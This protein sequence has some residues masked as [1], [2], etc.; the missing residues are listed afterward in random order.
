MAIFSNILQTYNPEEVYINW[1]TIEFNKSFA[2]DTFLRIL[3]DAPRFKAYNG[4]GGRVARTLNSIQTATVTLRL[5]QNSDANKRLMK[6]LNTASKGGN[7]D[8]APITIEDSSRTILVKLEDCYI[9]TIPEF[10]L[11]KQYTEVEWTL[12][13]KLIGGLDVPD[14]GAGGITG[15]IGG[16]F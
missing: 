15:T 12:K 1:D 16:L 13:A 7:G 6:K 11:G 10:S 9:D 2:P 14:S 8:L 5:M 3:P 4:I